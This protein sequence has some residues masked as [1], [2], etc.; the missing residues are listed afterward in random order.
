MWFFF[1]PKAAVSMFLRSL[2]GLDFD[3]QLPQPN[4]TLRSLICYSCRFSLPLFLR[5]NLAV[6][7]KEVIAGLL[8][9][10]LSLN[11]EALDGYCPIIA[12]LFWNNIIPVRQGSFWIISWVQMAFRLGY[13][14]K[15]SLQSKFKYRHI[16]PIS[17]RGFLRDFS[18]YTK[19]SV[20]VMSQVSLPIKTTLALSACS[21]L[22]VNNSVWI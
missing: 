21:P 6:F 12:T 13:D 14:R 19:C 17:L 10:K 8:L 3:T 5:N 11:V 16:Y 18:V 2:E 20:R 15:L 22:L 1:R 9:K 4:G 7:Q